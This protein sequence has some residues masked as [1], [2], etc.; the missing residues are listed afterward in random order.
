MSNGNYPIKKQ[1]GA[2]YSVWQKEGGTRLVLQ[3]REFYVGSEN[4]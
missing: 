1:N 2:A 4:S 3:R